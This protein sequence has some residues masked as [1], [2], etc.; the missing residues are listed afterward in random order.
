MGPDT[1]GGSVPDTGADAGSFMPGT[2]FDP[3]GGSGGAGFTSAPIPS[4]SSGSPSEDPQIIAWAQ[5]CLAHIV[6]GWVPQDGTLGATTLRAIRLFQDRAQLPSTGTLDDSTLSALHQACEQSAG[7]AAT[8]ASPAGPIDTASGAPPAT[9]TPA[10]LS[11]AQLSPAGAPPGTG[12]VAAP[13]TTP[14]LEAPDFPHEFEGTSGEMYE[15]E[16]PTRRAACLDVPEGPYSDRRFES[17]HHTIDV[18]EAIHVA[19]E[20][21]G[22]E[23]AGLLGVSVGAASIM[24]GA[25]VGVAGP[26]VAMGAGYSKAWDKISKEFTSRGYAWGVVT[27]AGGEKWDDVRSRVGRHSPNPN[28][29]DQHAGV[30]AQKA[31]NVGLAAGYLCGRELAWNPHKRNFFWGS[32]RPKFDANLRTQWRQDVQRFGDRPISWPERHWSDFYQQAMVLF[33]R[34]YLN[35]QG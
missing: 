5:S 2:A 25:V 18:L 17:I 9:G 35:D 32:I 7:D 3:R 27:G 24:V 16:G 33:A 15:M 28:A 34:Q 22:P 8:A 6:G 31:F 10:P 1:G 12:D 26:F 4:F 13:N 21:F 20:I 19:W 23:L 14:E 29:F 11:P 30:I